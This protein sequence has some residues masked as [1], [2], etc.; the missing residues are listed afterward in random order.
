MTT[1]TTTVTQAAV[2][3]PRKPRKPPR[4]LSANVPG[5]NLDARLV[6]PGD[7]WA[8]PSRTVTRKAKPRSDQLKKLDEQAADLYRRWVA[9]GKPR[10]MDDSPKAE[11]TVAPEHV[12]TLTSLLRKTADKAGGVPGK[13]IKIRQETRSS[14]KIAVTVAVMDRLES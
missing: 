3:K 11:Y 9:A 6:A 7:D 2:T 5:L 13:S 10:G 8:R 12:D 1:P 14:G 4:D